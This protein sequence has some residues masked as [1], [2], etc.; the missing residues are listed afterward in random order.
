MSGELAPLP[1][2]PLE[3]RHC[4]VAIE[5][6]PD[7][8]EGWWHNPGGLPG[9]GFNRCVGYDD[10]WHDAEPEPATGGPVFYR[11]DLPGDG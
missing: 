1:A 6:P 3:C 8:P 5:R 10:E 2:E 11:G 7:R 4:G 9:A